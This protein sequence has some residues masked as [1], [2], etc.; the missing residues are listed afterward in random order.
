[1]RLWVDA[2]LQFCWTIFQCLNYPFQ[3]ESGFTF[4]FFKILSQQWHWKSFE[5]FANGYVVDFL[6]SSLYMLLILLAA[7]ELSGDKLG[8]S[9]LSWCEFFAHFFIPGIYLSLYLSFYR[10]IFLSIWQACFLWFILLLLFSLINYY[11]IYHLGFF[12]W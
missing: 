7:K 4:L 11:R 10:S 9:L 12:L 1:M 3:F 8:F 2:H 5:C 6:H